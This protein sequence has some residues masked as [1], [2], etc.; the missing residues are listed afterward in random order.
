MGFTPTSR[1]AASNR[2]PPRPTACP[3]LLASDSDRVIRGLLGPSRFVEEHRSCSRLPPP[4]SLARQS[5]LRVPCD[6][7]HLPLRNLMLFWERF[8]TDPQIWNSAR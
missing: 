4:A 5:L 8:R 6:P 2:R 3:G 7:L 1:T